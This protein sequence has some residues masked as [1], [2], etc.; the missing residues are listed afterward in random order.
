[1][2]GGYFPR[3]EGKFDMN[4]SKVYKVKKRIASGIY[5]I[6][7]NNGGKHKASKR[8]LRLTW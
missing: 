7:D 3:Q 8:H 5:E 2:F 6:E 4:K 1:M